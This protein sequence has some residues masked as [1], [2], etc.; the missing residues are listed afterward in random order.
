MR[1]I[2]LFVALALA[3]P[4]TAAAQGT[5]TEGGVSSEN[6][7]WLDHH[8]DTLGVAEGGRLVGKTFFMTNN[9]QGLFAYDVSAPETPKKLGQLVL[10]HAAENEDVATN[11]R[12]LLL[13]QLG[14]VYHLSDGTVKQGHWLNV[15][16]VRDPANMQVVAKV[17]G[18]GDHTWDC[19]L[20]CTWAYS[21]SGQ[22]LDLRDPAN[23]VL[24]DKRWRDFVD[25]DVSP[26]F[27]HDV[28]EV[29][30][31]WVMVATTP[32]L[33]LDTH[34]PA[35][36]KVVATAPADSGNAHH[37]V[38]WPR[39]MK[40]RFIITASEGQNLGRCEAYSD[41]LLQ[42][43]DATG[44]TKAKTWQPTGAY[45]ASNGTQLDGNPPVSATWYGCSAHWA[46]THPYWHDGGLVAGAFYSHGAR[47]LQVGDDGQ[48]KEIGYFLAHGAGASAVYWITDRILYVADDTRGLDVI[49]YTGP[50]PP[51]PAA[52]APPDVR[53][54]APRAPLVDRHAP[55][56]SVRLK[57]LRG[58]RV[59]VSVRCD[60]DC[61]GR[62]GKRTFALR[63]GA[64]KRFVV[65][66]RRVTLTVNDR[67]GNRRV[68]RRSL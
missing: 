25:P 16:D 45:Q 3:L 63:A 53:P 21:A 29:A 62:L 49:R 27:A 46:E 9:N 59:R 60:E 7:E 28:T 10:P 41:A 6:V 68:V 1:L 34:D 44:W 43:W 65:R 2:G 11:G 15:I 32:M 40:D 24:L 38:V 54:A 48:P 57:R 36:P 39:A 35:N 52:P 64:T 17:D 67:A 22:I 31:G 55:R 37:N 61:W 42:V 19:L 30:P 20:D 12:I 4:A 51:A 13:S 14:D 66:G 5:V 8:E 26:G 56:A 18:G 33:L 23:P 50:L 58:R 47:L